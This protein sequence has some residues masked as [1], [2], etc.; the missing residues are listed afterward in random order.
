MYQDPS[1]IHRDDIDEASSTFTLDTSF[2]TLAISD[3]QHV[4]FSYESRFQ[5]FRADD[6]TRIYHLAGEITAPCCVQ[7]IVPF[8]GGSVMVWDGICSQQRTN[9]II[10]DGNCIAHHYINQVIRTILPPF[11]QHQPRLLFQQDN[12]R[13]HTA[14]VVQQFVAANKVNAMP[15]PA[16]SSD[17]SPIE[18]LWD[19]LGQRIGRRRNPPNNRDQLVQA[20]IHDWR[21]IP[22]GVIRRLTNSV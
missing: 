21:A 16:C 11:F 6:R 3:S 20:L 19:H 7:E 14:L 2:S 5:L 13:Q 18:Q 1:T 8:G 22:D 17:L 10:F 12:A 4:V 9:L 15:W